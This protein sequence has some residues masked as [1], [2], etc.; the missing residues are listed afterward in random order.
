[1]FKYY[2]M[3]LALIC[4]VVDRDQSSFKLAEDLLCLDVEELAFSGIRDIRSFVNQIIKV[5]IGKSTPVV[6]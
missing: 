2:M 3:N 1:M 5:W 4:R 6:P